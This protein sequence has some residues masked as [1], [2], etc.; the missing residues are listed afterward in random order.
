IENGSSC[1]AVLIRTDVQWSS[2]WV[3]TRTIH[4]WQEFYLRLKQLKSSLPTIDLFRTRTR[5]FSIINDSITYKKLTE[6]LQDFLQE[7]LKDEHMSSYELVYQFLNPSIVDNDQQA[8]NNSLKGGVLSQIFRNKT[9]VDTDDQDY[10]E[11]DSVRFLEGRADSI[12]KPL[13]QLINE[14]FEVK[15]MLKLV[16]IT[17]VQFIR[18]TFGSTINRQ[19]R[20]LIFGLFQENRLVSYVTMLRDTFWPNGSTLSIITKETRT[21]DEKLERR[22]QAKRKLL[23]SIPETFSLLIGY[24][25]TRGGVERLFE[26]FQDGRLNKHFFYNILLM[27]IGELFPEIRL[28]ER[29]QNDD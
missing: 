19:T 23:T 29:L 27:I 28:K 13:Y 14:I 17:L 25:N 1:L 11:I 4:A 8:Y 9:H 20:R 5:K 2:G 10:S 15:G 16:R 6:Q 21:D 18:S 24:E 7:I 3:V 26:L 12:A 22:H